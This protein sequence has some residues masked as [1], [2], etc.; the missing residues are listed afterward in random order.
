MLSLSEASL[1]ALGNNPTLSRA[2]P[3]KPMRSGNPVASRLE[4]ALRAGDF[5]VTAELAP[6]D[7]ANPEEVYKR[8][9]VFDG[10]V[11]AINATDGSGA[12][13]H[14][15][16]LAICALLH[17]AG[18]T[19]VMQ[20]SCRDRNRIAIQGDVLGAAALGIGN[21]L[22]LTGDGVAAVDHPDAKPVFDLG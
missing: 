15:S 19:M 9:A 21:I 1:M 17:R 18:Y 2:I 3:G 8:A 20:V 12:N 22:C 5:A 4:V 6:P 7:C 11:D 14:M 16:S 13:V 10:W